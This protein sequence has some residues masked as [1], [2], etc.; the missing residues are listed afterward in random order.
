[1]QKKTL[2]QL[3]WKLKWI[4]A[5]KEGFD[6][7]V[8]GCSFSLTPYPTLSHTDYS[9]DSSRSKRSNWSKGYWSGLKKFKVK[10]A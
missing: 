10:A 6:V 9:I 8:K 1:M 4:K 7:G 2:K 5:W 3:I